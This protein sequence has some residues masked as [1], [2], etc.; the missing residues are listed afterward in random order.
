MPPYR[1]FFFS[2]LFF[3]GGIF[4][5]SFWPV[6]LIVLITFLA[7]L[8]F[9]L[10]FI[11]EEKK[12]FVWLTVLVFFAV[13][14]A[15]Y[16]AWDDLN[17][18][19]ANVVFGKK[20]D[21][22]GVIVND[23]S[24]K[25]GSQEIVLKLSQPYSGNIL[26]KLARY[27][28]FHYGDEL[29][30][31]GIIKKPEPAGYE[32]YLAKEKIRGISSFPKVELI[33]SNR[34]SGIKAAL[35]EFKNKIIGS[36]Q[37]VLPQ[38]ESA[39]LTGLT[40]GGRSE[41]SQEFKNAMQLSGTTHL[42]ALSGYNITIIVWAVMGLLAYFLSK[43]LSFLLTIFIIIGFVLMTGAEASVVRAA[44]MGI[45]V[46]LARELGRLYDIKNAVV[47]AG[48]IMVLFN[49][50]VL[51][52]DVGFQLSFLA[53]LG[54]IY[55]RPAIARFFKMGEEPGF[56]GW[57]DN[58]LTTTSAQL[59]VAPVL[60][61]N[62]GSFSPTSLLANVLILGAVPVTMGLGFIIAFAS[63]VSYYLSLVFSWLAWILLSFEIFIINL[64]AK[65]SLTFSSALSWAAV[66]LYYI[67]IIGFTVYV[68]RNHSKTQTS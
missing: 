60:I 32:R 56:L 21:F 20:T 27:P 55:L 36:F 16:Y 15:L 37:K 30:L 25:A 44:V 11:F 43:R 8:I 61:I 2:A 68:G 38:K 49:P 67:I 14:G 59:A 47:L 63:F 26:I 34:G 17:F 4:L 18:R 66:F 3:L 64:F 13:I 41:F 50:K 62:F 5:A 6:A 40:L 28:E 10:L 24:L 57:R 51:A 35:F 9:F 29:N 7:A 42:V 1:I 33:G 53:L 31:N 19:S 23:P 54:I 65:L 39:F 12:I 52:F 45:L 48:L 46:L 22:K 58:F